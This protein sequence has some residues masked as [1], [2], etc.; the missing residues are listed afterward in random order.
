MCLEPTAGES[1]QDKDK[2]PSCRGRVSTNHM[3]ESY[4]AAAGTTAGKNKNLGSQKG[5]LTR[6]RLGPLRR[7]SVV[8]SVVVVFHKGKN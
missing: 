3:S 7:H 4:S 6:L 1:V 8:G 2:S 5:N